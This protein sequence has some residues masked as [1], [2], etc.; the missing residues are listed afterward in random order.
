MKSGGVQINDNVVEL[1]DFQDYLLNLNAYLFEYKG[2]NC[3][4]VSL[5][6]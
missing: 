6:L 1:L 2:N 4:I 3:N 5:V